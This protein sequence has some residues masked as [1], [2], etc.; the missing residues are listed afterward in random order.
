MRVDVTKVTVH[1]TA[2]R[3]AALAQVSAD[4]CEAGRVAEL[5]TVTADA[6]A[7]QVVLAPES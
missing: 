4:V 6:F 1:D 5:A 3:L 2:E 7:V